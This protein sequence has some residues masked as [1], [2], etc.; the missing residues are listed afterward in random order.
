MIMNAEKVRIEEAAYTALIDGNTISDYS[1]QPRLVS[2]NHTKG[3]K[4]LSSIEH[5]LRNCDSFAISVA[6]ITLG[7]I[8]PLLQ[9]LKELEQR[10][11]P[12]NILTTN[13][14]SFSDPRALKK[15]HELSNL[16]IRMY[17]CDR[18][19]EGFHTKGY[20]FKSNE[21]YRIIIGSSNL[22]MDAMTRNKEWNAE[23]VSTQNGR[24]V[25]QVIS[26][27]QKL[28]ESEYTLGYNQ[29]IDQYE[30]RYKIVQEQHRIAAENAVPSLV[31]Y[32]LTPNIM[33]QQ[34]VRNLRELRSGGANKALLISATGTGKTYASAFAMRD[35]KQ[36]KVLFL[37]HREQIARQAMRSYKNVLDKSMK[38]GLLSGNSHP[39]NLHDINYLFCTMLMMAKD[40]VMHQFT[41]DEFETI[42]IDE[43]HRT[44]AESYQKIMDYFRPQMWLGMTASPER[45]DNFDVFAAFDHNIAY[46]I[47]LQQALE[48]NMLCPFHYFGITDLIIDD[49]Y[50]DDTTEFNR[51]TSDTRV[52]YIIQQAEYYGYSGD[53]VKGLVF[54]S[55]KQEAVRMSQ[56]FNERPNR[57]QKRLYRTV[58]LTDQDSQDVRDQMV[59]RLESEDPDQC[60]DYIFTVGIFNEGVDI[61]KVNQVIMLRPTQSPIVFVQQLG[62]GLRL[63]EGK[64]F[65]VILDFIGNY[66]NNFMIP[67][68]LSGDRTY[69]KDNIRRYVQEGERIV[70]YAST[71]HFD[72][73]SRKQIYKAIDNA[74][75]NDVQLIKENYKNLKYKL[76]RIPSLMDFDT[77][78]EMDVLRIFDNQS[79]GSYYRFLVKYEKDYT[80]RLSEKE[81]KVIEFISKKLANG[82]RIEEL[83]LLKRILAYTHSISKLGLLSGLKNDLRQ[84]DSI[85]LS[86]DA[87][88]SVVRVMT[89]EFP[90][91][92]GK[93]TYKDCVLLQKREDGDYKPSETFLQMLKNDDFY[94]ILDELVDFGIHRNTRDY[95][96]RAYPDSDLVLYKKYNYEDV[97]RLLNWKN[98]IVP[99]NIGGYKYDAETRTFPVFINYD[100]SDNIQDT[101][102][103]E[104]RFLRPDSLISIS[105][106]NRTIQSED[107][108]NFIHSKERGINVELFVRKNKDDKI[109]KEFY[110]LG[111]MTPANVQPRE[112]IMPNTQATAVE[113]QWKLDYPVRDDIYDYIVNG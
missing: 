103:Y 51:L 53:R 68:A 12:G 23:I 14:L 28:W 84:D 40:D 110:Y 55:T 58:A 73:I 25:T 77:Y 88:S 11:I 39:G 44:G 69:N 62:R 100:K 106:S 72:E 48:E 6:F 9:T 56:A 76:G 52:N 70:P 36:K 45:T 10:G 87:A 101:V 104:D 4:V 26:E 95:K 61:P 35:E 90:S 60:I 42:I 43:A 96:P 2:N 65:V 15:L 54:C 24:Y 86:K 89:N 41:R 82:K 91:G 3:E 63:A 105:K 92:T 83:R 107:V 50:I 97:C 81:A 102:K 108:Q 94:Q 71:I 112:F 34:F 7:G 1:Y 22:T 8:T 59:E 80:I 32:R 111:R 79:L 16:T 13:Y 78:G 47:R 20:L 46:E 57:D 75:F 31:Q 64:E 85:D 49:Q 29:F 21:I 30:I 113:M 37:V 99:L 38:M 17:D 109:S 33:Q 93:N 27:F 5:E 67:I 66:K 19:E 18:A 98:N 74:N